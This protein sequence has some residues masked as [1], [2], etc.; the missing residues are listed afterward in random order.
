MKWLIGSREVD[1][2]V[3][4]NYLPAGGSPCF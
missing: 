4:W 2:D 1:R 3:L